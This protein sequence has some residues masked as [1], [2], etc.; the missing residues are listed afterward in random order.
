MMAEYYI[1]L[2]ENDEI[3]LEF[4]PAYFAGFN[5]YHRLNVSQSPDEAL[6]YSERQEAEKVA[7]QL[8]EVGFSVEIKQ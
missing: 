5:V 7:A 6:G 8:T 4:N 3:P 2:N 1:Q